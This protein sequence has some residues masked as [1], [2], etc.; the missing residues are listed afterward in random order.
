MEGKKNH[1]NRPPVRPN[2]ELKPTQENNSFMAVDSIPATISKPTLAPP[3]RRP[4][5]E[6]RIATKPKI[7][8][9]EEKKTIIDQTL[10]DF[11]SIRSERIIPFYNH[12]ETMALNTI[13]VFLEEYPESRGVF[14]QFE[15]L[16]FPQIEAAT[17][18]DLNSIDNI[19]MINELDR[20]SNPLSKLVMIEKFNQEAIALQKTLFR[21]GLF[22]KIVSHSMPEPQ[23]SFLLKKLTKLNKFIKV[24][25]LKVEKNQKNFRMFRDRFTPHSRGFNRISSDITPYL[26]KDFKFDTT[27]DFRK[28]FSDNEVG[29]KAEKDL[30]ELLSEDP[31]V[32]FGISAPRFSK[33]DTIKKADYIT[34]EMNNELSPEIKNKLMTLVERITYYN[35]AMSLIQHHHSEEGEDIFENFKK[36]IRVSK[37]TTRIIDT[38]TES[39]LKG[40][41]AN[42]DFL[43]TPV[44]GENLTDRFPLYMAPKQQLKKYVNGKELNYEFVDD[45]GELEASFLRNP[46]RLRETIESL[47]IELA[48][49][50]F[51]HNITA[52]RI[53]IKN[54]IDSPSIQSDISNDKYPGVV[55]GIKDIIPNRRHA[56]KVANGNMS[57]FELFVG[58]Q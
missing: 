25:K 13:E 50:M 52:K 56:A 24:V 46:K 8:S 1:L 33:A 34:F 23:K 49:L 35:Y 22:F 58:P 42:Y 29:F 21:V 40:E 14:A 16:D 7:Q 36:R 10:L 44:N 55:G 18:V 27:F 37:N 17:V 6:E 30:S 5:L 3:P 54:N 41:E 48:Q 26:D 12:L 20:N 53:Q 31:N 9:P 57:I 4:Q 45:F 28:V 47:K 38:Y 2:V 11:E 43:D 19:D 32:I 51:T 39:V 15:L